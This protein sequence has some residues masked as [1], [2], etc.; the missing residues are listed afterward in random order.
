MTIESRIRITTLV[1]ILYAVGLVLVLSWSS[2]QVGRGISGIE[3]ASQI[4]RSAFM[5]RVLMKDYLEQGNKRI[6]GQWDEQNLRL[7]RLL[8]EGQLSESLD[9]ALLEGIRQRYQAVNHLYPRLIEMRASTETGDLNHDVTATKMLSALMFLQLEQLVHTANDLSMT[10]QT[11]TL[12]K[13]NFLRSSIVALGIL[14]VIVILVNI[15][16]I[17]RSVVYPLQMLSKGAESVGA[18]DLELVPETKSDDEVGK[19]TLAFNTMIAGL[20]KRTSDLKKAHSELELRIEERT[21]A[22]EQIRTQNDLLQAVQR[23]QTQFIS[24][25]SPEE[26]FR[27]L[28]HDLLTSTDSEFGFI[29]EIIN[30][31]EGEIYLKDRAIADI[32]WDGES[33]K[34]YQKF[35]DEKGLDFPIIRGLWGDVVRTGNPVISNDPAN[36]PRRGGMPEGHP[37]LSSFLGLPFR[38]DGE[39]IGV[40]GIANRPGGY[41]QELVDFLQPYL[42][43]CA[44]IIEAYRNENR[45]KDAEA[46]LVS[47]YAQLEQRVLDRTAELE[48]ANER[49]VREIG[50]RKRAEQSATTE[51]QRFNEVLDILPAY[52]V[53]LAPD[54]HVPFANRFFEERFGK[55]GGKRC[56]EYLFG[57]TEPC[58]VCET[59]TVLKTNAPH[60]WEWTGPDGRNYDIHDFPFADTDASPLIMEVGIDITEQKSAEAEREKLITE[61]ETKNAELERFI[62]SVSHDL[63][64]PLIT[65]MT[66]LGFIEHEIAEGN[67][68]NLNTDLERISRAASKMGQLLDE[69]L[70]LSRIGRMFNPPT[71]IPMRDLV[72]EAVELVSGRIAQR[73]VKITIAPDLPVLYGDHPRLLDILQNLIENAVKFMGDQPNPEIEIGAREEGRDTVLYVRDNG[74]GIEACY[75]DKIFR[76]FDK[77]DQ[78]T[79][80]TGIG[81]ALVKRIVEVHNGRIWVETEGIGKGSTF[82]FTLPRTVRVDDGEKLT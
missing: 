14:A 9:T 76:L 1:L 47:A 23:A 80:G 26:L 44:N 68:D 19:L 30:T 6:L 48:S 63:K 59:Y 64:S 66:F 18:G 40:A 50:E 10:T 22:Y 45:R 28:L 71:E 53:L 13:R 12:K 37:P 79:E 15:H 7:G 77:L 49:L 38:S 11:L 82:C 36:D 62:Y 5:L 75:H 69:V 51:R 78:K 60:H 52:V 35:A 25:A 55:S 72:D 16:L 32:S 57:R 31:S 20:R 41:T 29:G 27:N 33:R 42:A 70:E 17:R 73:G 43:T 65:I 3:T 39:V 2:H 24:F 21:A 4:N 81:L 54:Y 34:T 74:I 67:T 46:E 61:L 8:D 58:E 56:F